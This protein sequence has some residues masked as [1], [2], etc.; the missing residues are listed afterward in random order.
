MNSFTPN[1]FGISINLNKLLLTYLSIAWL[2]MMLEARVMENRRVFNQVFEDCSRCGI[3]L[4]CGSE[5]KL[6]S[7][8]CAH[9]L[10]FSRCWEE[11][12][13][14]ASFKSSGLHCFLAS[15]SRTWVLRENMR[16]IWEDQCKC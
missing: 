8:F 10:R 7:Q 12:S 2:R 16:E 11:K 5:R 4:I 3:W 6:S 13:D 15:R 1:M 9:M 14:E